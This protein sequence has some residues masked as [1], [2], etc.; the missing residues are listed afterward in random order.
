MP[1]LPDKGGAGVLA[2]N[3]IP[4]EMTK[5][6]IYI[7]FS[8]PRLYILFIWVKDCVFFLLNMIISEHNVL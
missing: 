3:D 8:L 2:T 6:T 1:T 7:G 5:N 4:D